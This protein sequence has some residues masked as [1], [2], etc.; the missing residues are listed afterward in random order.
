MKHLKLLLATLA[1]IFCLTPAFAGPAYAATNVFKGAC[2]AKGS[3]DSSACQQNGKDPL[4]GAN[5]LLVKVSRI[6]SFM[7]GVAAIILILVSGLMYVMSS[8][9]SSRVASAKTTLIYAAVGLVIVG[10]AQ[11]IVV[12]VLNVL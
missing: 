7:A 8:G 1:V 6:I 2:E 5:G 9:D 10:V 12:L 4:T 11:G 3:G